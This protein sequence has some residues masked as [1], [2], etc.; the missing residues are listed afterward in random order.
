MIKW[1]TIWHS[2][3][4]KF[5]L[6]FLVVGMIPLLVL[7]VLSLNQFTDQV[8][9][10]TENNFKQMMLYLAKNA[11][12]ILRNYNGIS[13]SMYYNSID[14]AGR[15]GISL[16]DELNGFGR[17]NR[18]TIDDFLKSILYS[19]THI[20]NAFFVR[21]SDSA[22]YNQSRVNK[23]L[24]S[25]E[26][27][28]PVKWAYSLTGKPRELA[29]FP[30]HPEIYFSSIRPVITFARNFNDTSGKLGPEAQVLGT[31]YFDV[32]LDIF[33]KLFMQ[34]ALDPRDELFV[35]D[36]NGYI[37]YS[38]QEDKLGKRFDELAAQKSATKLLYSE[39]IPFIGGQVMGLVSKADFYASLTQI[40]SNVI[41]AS[42]ICLLAL[43]ALGALFSRTFTRPVLDI[44]RLMARVE[45]GHLETGIKTTRKDEMGRLAHGFN[46]MI[47]RLKFF[48]NDAYVAEIKRKQAE[49]NALKTQIQP[50]FLYNTLEV[51][52]MSAV[53]DD[54]MGVAKMIQS[55]SNQLEYVIDF[56]EEWVTVRRELEHLKTYFHL[57]EVRFDHRISLQVVVDEDLADAL[58]LKLSIQPLVENAVQHG[59]KPN[60]GKG[61]V[62]V[63]IEKSGTEGL[64]VTVFDNGIGMDSDT[65]VRLQDQLAMGENVTGKSIGL[66]NVHARIRQ[67]FGEPYGITIES[68]PR[69]GTSIQML[70]P[71]QREELSYEK[72]KG[73]AGG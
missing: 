1:T 49:L 70:Y 19:D 56:G 31:M 73:A 14:I 44:M 8:E 24:D 36:G 10:N 17:I 53:A 29:I 72:N 60:K 23:V 46:R 50:H 54:A 28:P 66:K 30:P 40:R 12:D 48:I 9:R 32:D 16:E 25:N 5:S 4:F 71:L 2:M 33:D 43:L 7:S 39:P 69:I 68:Q 45:S 57:I 63:T 34:V 65:Q 62:L 21:K 6:A 59:I 27:Y 35:V 26:P 18:M 47:E 67:A 11:D 52:R 22:V 58:I 51:I 55:L 42:A 61:T 3:F 13:K 38:N 37:L 20:E 64:A 41:I 15:H